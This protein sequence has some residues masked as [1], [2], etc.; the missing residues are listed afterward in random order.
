MGEGA[1]RAQTPPALES[2]VSSGRIRRTFQILQVQI[3]DT[4][5]LCKSAGRGASPDPREITIVKQRFLTEVLTALL[6]L[7]EV[8]QF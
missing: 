3:L 1:G 6:V 8:L 2:Q 5:S 7:D 4:S